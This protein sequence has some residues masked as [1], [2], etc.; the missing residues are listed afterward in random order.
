MANLLDFGFGTKT[1]QQKSKQ[2][3]HKYRW[4]GLH[5][6]LKSFQNQRTSWKQWKDS[7]ESRKKHLK[8]I[9]MIR[10]QYPESIK[11]SYNWITKDKEINLKID[12][13]LE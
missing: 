5:Q 2:Q 3:Q 13:G 6:K 11:T 8:F 7:L 4:I 1:E 12:E 9:Y 10:V